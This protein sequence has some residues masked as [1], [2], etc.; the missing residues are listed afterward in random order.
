MESKGRL[1]MASVRLFRNKESLF[2]SL[3]WPLLA[4]RSFQGR[5]RVWDDCPIVA[6]CE[7]RGG[8]LTDKAWH[9]GYS[10]CMTN[11]TKRMVLR[12]MM[13]VINIPMAFQLFCCYL[14]QVD[15]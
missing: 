14:R 15:V 12:A 2:S 10:N 3:L 6:F 1:Q 4:M 13:P 9:F 11:A 8:C 5:L 7:R